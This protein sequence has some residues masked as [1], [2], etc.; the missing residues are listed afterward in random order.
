VTQSVPNLVWTVVFGAVF[1][2]KIDD[3]V[4]VKLS[5]RADGDWSK[6]LGLE[7]VAN[8]PEL[9]VDQVVLVLAYLRD[10][11]VK[12]TYLSTTTIARNDD[13]TTM[14]A[15]ANMGRLTQ[16]LETTFVTWSA[17][18]V[19]LRNHE[20]KEATIISLSMLRARYDPDDFD[21]LKRAYRIQIIETAKDAEQTARLH[22]LAEKVGVKFDA[23]VDHVDP[24]QDELYWFA[25]PDDTWEKRAGRAGYVILRKGEVY[26]AKI[27]IM[28]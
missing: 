25:T 18:N 5:L 12:C 6:P 17:S 13:V 4:C 28:N 2:L 27:E 22:I 10:G 14:S 15:V 9:G 11:E 1:K 20:T 19:C 8:S 24:A 21:A 7:N 16:V 26:K 23:F 3:K